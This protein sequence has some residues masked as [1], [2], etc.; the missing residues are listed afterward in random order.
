MGVM[1]AQDTFQEKLS[2]STKGIKF[3]ITYL[4]N[5]LYLSEGHFD[6]YLED[7][8]KVLVRLKKEP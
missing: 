4:D 7:V 6:D 5:L 8:E 3:T 2:N 1:W